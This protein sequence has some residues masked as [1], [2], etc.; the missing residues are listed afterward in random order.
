LW[1][2]EKD[3]N[4]VADNDSSI[5]TISNKETPLLLTVWKPDNQNAFITLDP[6]GLFVTNMAIKSSGEVLST[7]ADKEEQVIDNI[8]NARF[9]LNWLN[10]SQPI[11]ILSKNVPYADLLYANGNKLYQIA[12][13]EMKVISVDTVANTGLPENNNWLVKYIP[14][15]GTLSFS[16]EINEESSSL[17]IS[18]IINIDKNLL[19]T[20]DMNETTSP[21]QILKTNSGGMAKA[22]VKAEGQI[23]GTIEGTI[24]GETEGEEG[25][26]CICEFEDNEIIPYVGTVEVPEEGWTAFFI[27]VKFPG[28]E[29]YEP[30]LKDLDYVFSTRVVVVPDTYP[31]TTSSTE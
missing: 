13:Q 14:Q 20:S 29:P 11:N 1:W 10:T 26:P 22:Y 27:Q 19:L 8:N 9:A 15:S 24:E 21:I 2:K 31:D 6:L 16:N 18:E 7:L 12:L 28:P 17:K 23:E 30:E 4:N 25:P 3:L 5:V